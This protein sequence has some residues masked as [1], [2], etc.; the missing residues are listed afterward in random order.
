[1]SDIGTWNQ[2][3]LKIQTNVRGAIPAVQGP[4]EA[5][6][7]NVGTAKISIDGSPAEIRNVVWFYLPNTFGTET[8]FGPAPYDPIPGWTP[9]VGDVCLA[10]FVG[11]GIG[12]PYVVSFPFAVPLINGVE[13]IS[14]AASIYSGTGAPT[15]A[16]V[17]GDRYLRTDTPTV[18]LQ[19]EYICTVTGAA[20]L[21][22]WVGIL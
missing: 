10:L 17:E 20:G 19:R 2:R 22:T 18:S 5:V 13:K 1:M 6:I 11:N 9:A 15:I 7:T 14:G 12:R 8:G 4:Q 16:G 21:A 3:I